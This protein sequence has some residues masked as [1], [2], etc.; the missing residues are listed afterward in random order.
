RARLLGETADVAGADGG[1][2]G[3]EFVAEVLGEEVVVAAAVVAVLGHGQEQTAV[4]ADR[5]LVDAPS[6]THCHLGPLPRAVSVHPGWGS[7]RRTLPHRRHGRE[8]CA[9]RITC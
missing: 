9:R 8:T 4:G 7:N 1:Q 2:V 6:F 5:E 3:V